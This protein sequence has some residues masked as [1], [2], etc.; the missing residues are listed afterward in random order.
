VMQPLEGKVIL[1]TGVSGGIGKPVT[2]LLLKL[3]AQVIGVD[4][5]NQDSVTGLLEQPKILRR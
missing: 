4:I 1:L 5:S 2:N 3:G